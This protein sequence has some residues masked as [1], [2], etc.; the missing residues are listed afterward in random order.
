VSDFSYM[1]PYIILLIVIL[2]SRKRIKTCKDKEFSYTALGDD[3]SNGIAA[4]FLRGFTFRVKRH[5]KSK[6]SKVIFNNL[7]KPGFTSSNLLFQLRND[8]DIRKCIKDSKVV[9]ISIGINNLLDDTLENYNEIDGRI[10]R[11]GVEQFREDWIF[12]LYYLRN[13]IGTKAKIYIM[14]LYNPYEEDDPNYS[15]AEYYIYA[16]NSI[17]KNEF[18]MK[19]F[20]YDV[21]DIYE[22]FKVGHRETLTLFNSFIRM[23]LPNRKGYEQIAQ[24][25]INAFKY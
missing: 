10:A 5:F 9:T 6:F 22:L 17:I 11:K 15:I 12:I 14:T 8:F 21:V 13:C 25:F 16:I 23:P 7:A 18:W 4:F 3:L 19:T 24:A 2:F 1:L 20:K